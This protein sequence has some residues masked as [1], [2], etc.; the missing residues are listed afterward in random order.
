[1]K[2]FVLLCL[3]AVTSYATGTFGGPTGGSGGG[4]LSPPTKDVLCSYIYNP[5]EQMDD[6]GA[7]FSEF[8]TIDD[9]NGPAGDI[10]SYTCWGISQSSPPSTLDLLVVEDFSSTPAGSPVSSY[11]YDVDPVNSGYTYGGYTIWVVVLDLSAN[12]LAVDGSV[13]LG[14][15]R[16]DG[17]SWYPMGGTTVEVHDT[18]GYRTVADGWQWE[19]FSESLQAGSLFQIIQG[20]PGS[21]LNRNT[22]ATIKSMY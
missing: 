2:A 9:Y 1:M 20:T 5:D 15:Y 10:E 14:T 8:A 16:S 17:S 4:Y 3:V 22:W 13:W 11:S 21:T 7:S 6:V 12:P 19:P 18:E